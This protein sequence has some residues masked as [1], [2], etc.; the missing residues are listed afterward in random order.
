MPKKRKW[1]IEE[2]KKTK[3]VTSTSAIVL[4][5]RIDS[6]LE[7]VIRYFENN[8]VENLHDV[9]ISIRRVRYSMELFI[10]CFEKKLF[11]RFYR[12]VEKLQD[13]SGS[14]RDLDVLLENVKSLAEKEKITV[15]KNLKERVLKEKSELEES[16]KIELMKFLHSK[17]FKDFTKEIH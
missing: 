15:S 16:F 14:V 3:A 13:L 10:A 17:I 5:D 11:L 6:F 7:T 1:E 8:T 9:R 12:K 2:L 4:N